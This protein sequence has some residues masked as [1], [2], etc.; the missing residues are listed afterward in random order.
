MNGPYHDTESASRY[1]G[2]SKASLETMR[3]K[4]IG[5]PYIKLGRSVRY[6][7]S[8]LEDYMSRQQ[9]VL[10]LESEEVI[11]QRRRAS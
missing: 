6:A 7:Q 4:K 1:L 11:A 8:D 2:T 5:P 3:S 10:T 9:R